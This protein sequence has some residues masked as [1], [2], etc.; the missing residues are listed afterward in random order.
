[1]SQ[2]ISNKIQKTEKFH[3]H[4]ILYV[5]SKFWVNIY[6]YSTDYILYAK[7][8]CVQ[9]C[10]T[11]SV[12][13]TLSFNLPIMTCHSDNTTLSSLSQTHRVLQPFQKKKKTSMSFS[14]Q[15]TKRNK[16]KQP[17]FISPAVTEMIS[18]V[19]ILLTSHLTR[20]EK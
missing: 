1:M 16:T 5:F 4:N 3:T 2:T 19:K 18:L 17:H 6:I 15:K 20:A 7:I 12:D 14:E 10:L 8:H 11:G 9:K 13:H